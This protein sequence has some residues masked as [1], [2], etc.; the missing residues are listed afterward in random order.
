MTSFR[1][2]RR[3][4]AYDMQPITDFNEV[5]LHSLEVIYTHLF[6]TKGPLPGKSSV[7]GGTAAAQSMN[8]RIR[9]SIFTEWLPAKKALGHSPSSCSFFFWCRVGGSI[10]EFFSAY[11]YACKDKQS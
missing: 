7:G 9:T 2:V 3:S 6:N 8:V 10:F 1:G 11:E 5:T 4:V